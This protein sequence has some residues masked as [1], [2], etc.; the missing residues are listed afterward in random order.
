MADAIEA[1]RAAIL[2]AEREQLATL[3]AWLALADWSLTATPG[4]QHGAF[5]A[6]RWGRA[7]DLMDLA[8]VAEFAEMVAP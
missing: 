7:R 4:S 6:S 2:A 8:A 1:F 3:R 5:T